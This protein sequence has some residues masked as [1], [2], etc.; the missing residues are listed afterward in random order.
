MTKVVAMYHKSGHVCGPLKMPLLW[1]LT[2]YH[3]IILYYGLIL[4]SRILLIMAKLS[5]SRPKISSTQKQK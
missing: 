1:E 3:K 4:I 2:A 5:W